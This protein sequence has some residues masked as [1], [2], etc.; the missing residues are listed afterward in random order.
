VAGTND[1]DIL[2]SLPTVTANIH[3]IGFVIN[4]YSGEGLCSLLKVF[5]HQFDSLMKRDIAMYSMSHTKELNGQSQLAA[6][7]LC[8]A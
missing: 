6:D 4:S 2:L 3:H 8:P 7:Y 1:E 5:C